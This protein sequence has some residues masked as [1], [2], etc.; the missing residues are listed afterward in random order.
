MLRSV[1]ERAPAPGRREV[2]DLM[3][4]L[5]EDAG[6]PRPGVEGGGG[7]GAAG[8][9][10]QA[11]I[12]RMK[13]QL[14][15][16]QLAYAA[17]AQS[18]AAS[19][20]SGGGGAGG[21]GGAPAATTEELS[22]IELRRLQR[23]NF[24]DALTRFFLTPTPT[25]RYPRDPETGAPVEMPT[26]IGSGEAATKFLSEA[27]RPDLFEAAMAEHAADP[28]KLE[29]EINA[30]YKKLSDDAAA[31]AIDALV[32]MNTVQSDR[33]VEF[34]RW[35]IE[36][37]QDD[38]T[39]GEWGLQLPSRVLNGQMV[40]NYHVFHSLFTGDA[41]PRLRWYELGTVML[42]LEDLVVDETLYSSEADVKQA[43]KAFEGRWQTL[44]TKST[45]QKDNLNT[46]TQR[47]L[48]RNLMKREAAA[49]Q[50]NEA[51]AK[52]QQE[53]NAINGAR[54]SAIQ[55]MDKA[56]HDMFQWM[57]TLPWNVVE[58]ALLERM[59]GR[60]GKRQNKARRQLESLCVTMNTLSR[61]GEKQKGQL[62][63]VPVHIF[64]FMTR[65][66]ATNQGLL[67]VHAL[68]YAR[69]AYAG[70]L[71]RDDLDNP[72]MWSKRKDAAAKAGR[73]PNL[74]EDWVVYK[75]PDRSPIDVVAIRNAK[76]QG[77]YTVQ[78]QPPG[79]ASVTTYGPYEG[80][81]TI[82]PLVDF[83][84]GFGAVAEH[85]EEMPWLI[86]AIHWKINNLI[87]KHGQLELFANPADQWKWWYSKK[88]G[89]ATEER[90][91]LIQRAYAT[92]ILTPKSA[93]QVINKELEDADPN[94]ERV[95][96]LVSPEAMWISQLLF[97]KR[98]VVTVLIETA[99]LAGGLRKPGST[100]ASDQHAALFRKSPGDKVEWM[101]PQFLRSGATAP[102]MWVPQEVEHFLDP[103]RVDV[104][105]V[106]KAVD[107]VVAPHLNVEV[108]A[109]GYCGSNA[110]ERG[111]CDRGH[112]F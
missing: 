81:P 71:Y 13:Q 93:Y 112:R 6:L 41:A 104:R 2:T 50:D 47:K 59:Q 101:V 36:R 103:N 45:E 18:V 51:M 20:S 97:P 88:E 53:Q 106:E 79:A 31:Q 30:L 95:S 89:E 102:Q 52:F 62:E 17:A 92:A 61:I 109:V 85:F 44:G 32:V 25:F 77:G 100:D 111:C 55:A 29:T 49:L 23:R 56:T 5:Y 83:Q 78:A 4:G 108:A 43:L 94:Y 9:A 3:R 84:D 35:I 22:Q 96:T 110:S 66:D 12:A 38:F 73:D 63:L 70:V 11:E 21:A 15:Q 33:D 90:P 39:I 75:I 34:V 27:E 57:W 54:N 14:Q 46:I 40:S 76:R 107:D 58:A 60:Y 105:D 26:L 16:L 8:G 67:D 64:Y 91:G 99:A 86:R 68:E 80:D 19:S 82:A 48:A 28:K 69:P 24:V 98:S 87:K 37:V 7:G 74:V 42:R 72:D 10:Q 1:L 65:D